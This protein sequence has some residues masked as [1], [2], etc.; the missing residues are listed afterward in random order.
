MRGGISKPR[1]A[2]MRY[3]TIRCLISWLTDS[4]PERKR[5]ELAGE[6]TS[7][8]RTTGSGER[9]LD[10]HRDMGAEQ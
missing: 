5:K 4:I 7:D 8:E 2:K 6:V 3:A 10:R 9:G 1:Y